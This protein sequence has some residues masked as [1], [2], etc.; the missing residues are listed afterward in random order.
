MPGHFVDPADFRITYQ[1][2]VSGSLGKLVACKFRRIVKD[3]ITARTGLE[4]HEG[5][6][7]SAWSDA[8]RD[9]RRSQPGRQ[10]ERELRPA[11]AA[12]SQPFCSCGGTANSIWRQFRSYISLA[13]P[14]TDGH[15]TRSYFRNPGDRRAKM[16]AGFLPGGIVMIFDIVSVVILFQTIRV[17][18]RL[19]GQRHSDVLDYVARQKS[20]LVSGSWDSIR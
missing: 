6:Q 16:P 3:S 11:V 19:I 9:R 17:L 10:H 4:R 13:E 5:R 14:G 18:S 20:T 12:L 15:F 7:R 8:R 1:A 2:G